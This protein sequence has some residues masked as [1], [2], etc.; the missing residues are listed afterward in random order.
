M[1]SFDFRRLV[2][3]QARVSSNSLSWMQIQGC[4]HVEISTMGYEQYR[5]IFMKVSAL[6]TCRYRQVVF[7]DDPTPVGIIGHLANIFNFET[8]ISFLFF[9][10]FR[11][12]ESPDWIL[13]DLFT[14]IRAT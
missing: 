5:A 10:L 13:F 7:E 14:R 4:D 8:R 12:E 6:W 11:S 1:H 3:I 9:F 2:P